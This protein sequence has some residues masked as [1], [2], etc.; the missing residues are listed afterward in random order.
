MV[1]L[2]FVKSLMRKRRE[3]RVRQLTRIVR[4]TTLLIDSMDE[5]LWPEEALAARRERA[6]ASHERHKLL[7]KLD[8][9]KHVVRTRYDS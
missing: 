9:E 7:V 1:H 6:R 3:N 2:A 8:K 5:D 4:A